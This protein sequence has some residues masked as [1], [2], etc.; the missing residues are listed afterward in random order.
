[1]L[2]HVDDDGGERVASGELDV[3]ALLVCCC[4]LSV[5]VGAILGVR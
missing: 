4:E 2:P 5:I 1:L 3:A